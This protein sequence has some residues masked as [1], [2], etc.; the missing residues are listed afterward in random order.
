MRI[1]E[2]FFST[3][4]PGRGTGMGLAVVYGIVKDSGGVI[5]VSSTPGEGSV[6]TV[7][8][9]RTKAGSRARRERKQLIQ[10]G[11]KE[12]VLFVDDEE[13]IVMVTCVCLTGWDT[14]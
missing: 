12:R 10:Q 4:K 5:T 2:P 3:K 9:P 1:F 6:F 8:L 13:P 14:T 7:Y 11:R